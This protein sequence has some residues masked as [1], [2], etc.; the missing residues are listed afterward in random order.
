[1]FGHISWELSWKIY[2]EA[3]QTYERLNNKVATKEYLQSAL[4]NSPDNLKWKVWLISSRTEYKMGNILQA[5][6]LIERCCVEVP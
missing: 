4:M 3:A 6:K 2:I 1:M 5:R